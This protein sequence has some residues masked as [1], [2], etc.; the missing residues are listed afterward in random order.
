MSNRSIDEIRAE[1][2]RYAS[3]G[4][5]NGKVA[6]LWPHDCK[7]MLD[8]LHRLD[9]LEELLQQHKSERRELLARI[10]E[11]EATQ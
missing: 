3:A 1:L 4:D 9:D 7:L 8:A 11:L 2:R 5:D 6:M 10:A